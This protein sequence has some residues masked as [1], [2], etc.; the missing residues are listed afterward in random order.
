M[1]YYILGGWGRIGNLPIPALFLAA[2]L[3]MASGIHTGSA[4]IPTIT[5]RMKMVDRLPYVT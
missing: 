2:V 1:L 4:S 5:L 3:I